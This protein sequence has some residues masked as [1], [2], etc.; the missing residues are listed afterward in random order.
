MKVECVAPNAPSPDEPRITRMNTDWKLGRIGDLCALR[1]DQRYPTAGDNTPYLSLEHLDPGAFFAT[2]FGKAGEMLSSQ[3][4]FSSGEVLYGKLRPY[5]DKVVLANRE[6]AC[7]TEL[8][9]LTPNSDV[10]PL[11]LLS[12][13][14]S[15][16]FVQHAI[17]TTH[18]VNHPRTSWAAIREFELLIAPPVEQRRIAAVLGKL[19]RTV[20]LEAAQERATRELK[21]SVMHRL[22]TRGLRG[23]SLRDTPLGPLPK[24]WDVKKIGSFASVS[25]GGTPLRSV[26]EYWQGGT[27]PWVKTGEIKYGVITESEEKITETGMKNSAARLYPKGT[28]LMAMYGQGI[29]RGKVALLGIEA[30]T[31]QAC[32]AIIP[33]SDASTEYLFCYLA[34]AYDRVRELGHGANQKNL[35][36]ELI[37]DVEVPVPADKD[38][39]KEIAAILA[40]ID[41]KIALH[42]AR[43]R[44]RQELFRSTLHALMTARLRIPEVSVDSI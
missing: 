41:R 16:E 21:Q 42:A 35:S 6:G 12:I 7:T 37:A 4:R 22:F 9:V 33:K 32:A 14:H 2:R 43:R 1:Q 18:G 36:G 31:N 17:Q 8:L 40:A 39:Q 44:A 11:Y 28:L 10:D 38:E 29:T 25:S 34:F 27:I 5:L 19:Q 20:E 3:N 13:L 30:T 23:E 26:D 24:S 15:Q